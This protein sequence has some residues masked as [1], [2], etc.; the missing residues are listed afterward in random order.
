MTGFL[1]GGGGETQAREA[2]AINAEYVRGWY[3]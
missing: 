2:G 3:R 1:L